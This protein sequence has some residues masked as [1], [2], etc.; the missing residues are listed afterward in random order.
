MPTVTFDKKEVLSIIGDIDDKTLMDR[1]SMIGTDLEY[2][3]EK[4][5]CVEIFPNRP[6]MLSLEGFAFA[7][8]NFVGRGGGFHDIIAE[9]SDYK[10]IVD[11]IM[12]GIRPYTVAAVVKGVS[13]DDA[14]LQ[15]IIQL[16]EKLDITFCRRR[17]KAAI[18]IYPYNKISWPVSFTAR[19]PGDIAFAPL[20]GE[21]MSAERILEEHPTARKHAHLLEGLQKYPIF[22]DAKGKILSMPP[23]IN[24]DDTGRVGV[25]DK[26][27]FIEVSGHDIWTLEKVLNIILFSLQCNKGKVYSVSIEYE[28][29]PLITP[30]VEPQ[31]LD[32]SLSYVNKLLGLNLEEN[33]FNML[34]GRMGLKHSDSQV[35]VP[36]YR[37]DIMHPIDIAEDIAVAYG[38]EN[39]ESQIP[40]ISTIAREDP[41]EIFKKRIISHCI[42]FGFQETL[43]YHL[44]PGHTESLFGSSP[45]MLQNPMNEEYDALRSTIIGSLL[46]ILSSNKHSELPREIFEIGRVFNENP[47]SSET[48]IMEN[49][50]LG[51]VIEDAKSDYTMIRQIFDSIMRLYI[52]DYD[53]SEPENH[54]M[55]FF[56]GRYAIA[57]HNGILIAEFGEVNPDVL[58]GLKIE[59]PVCAMK[60]DIDSLFGILKGK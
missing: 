17:R 30:N 22:E 31:R 38:Y 28:N 8:R 9:K 5:I 24:S 14:S 19:N 15:S 27:L 42:G 52:I 45:I 36:S 40:K 56:E 32:V 43:S 10:V 53:V 25:D 37:T 13:F 6:D 29:E 12:K 60:L 34:L 33:E 44:I 26:D 47:A 51:I 54:N 55:L 3:D 7:L 50:E 1:I 2:V 46:G 57:K 59:N 21:E 58:F 41:K 16:Q 35:I 18:G 23:I 49:D 11:P 4:E 39:F 48:G 20:E